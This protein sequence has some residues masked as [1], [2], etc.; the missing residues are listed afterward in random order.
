MKRAVNL[1]FVPEAVELPTPGPT[2]QAQFVE[3]KLVTHR[4]AFSWAEKLRDLV[5]SGLP[6][7]NVMTAAEVIELTEVWNVVKDAKDGEML[8]MED[9]IHKALMAHIGRLAWTGFHPAVGEMLHDLQEAQEWKLP[10]EATPETQKP[11]RKT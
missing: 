7:G 5:K 11:K 6:E 3:G 2:G 1:K 10:D 8:I 9:S 4:E